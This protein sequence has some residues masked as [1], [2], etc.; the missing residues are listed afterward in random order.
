MNTLETKR[1]PKLQLFWGE[2]N[3]YDAEHID[4]LNTFL[5]DSFL[6]AIRRQVRNLERQTYLRDIRGM[7]QFSISDHG[8]DN[9]EPLFYDANGAYYR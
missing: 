3:A 5:H 1:R 6:P 2:V 7:I 9:D 4:N 8:G